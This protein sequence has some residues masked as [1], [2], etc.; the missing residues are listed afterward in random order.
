MR[1]TLFDYGAG[2]LHSL[3]KALTT[4][5]GVDVRVEEDPV[6]AVDTEVL[7]LPGVG[8]FGA[9]AA[10]LAPGREAMRAALERGLPC[11]GICLGMQLLFESSDE[12]PGQGLGYF[13]GRVTRLNARRVP[14]MGWNPVD[15]DTTVP[16]VPLEIAYY[17]NSFVCRAQDV[18]LVTAWTTHEEDR[19]PAA[20]RRGSVVG[21]QFHPEKS[22]AAGVAFIQGFLREVAS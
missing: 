22:S 7:V 17:A 15:A 3:G 8:A 9:A 5:P 2:N 4:V 12:G 16:G 11:L 14:Q 19:F 10:R 13:A 18:S 6:R 21:V 1:V 20:V